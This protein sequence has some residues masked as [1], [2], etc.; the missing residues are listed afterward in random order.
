MIE[1][2]YSRCYNPLDG[3]TLPG[4]EQQQLLVED[5][6]NAPILGGQLYQMVHAF[7]V[8]NNHTDALPITGFYQGPGLGNSS[9]PGVT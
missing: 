1:N 2:C 6:L 5:T 7:N 3:L 9:I 8:I 4:S